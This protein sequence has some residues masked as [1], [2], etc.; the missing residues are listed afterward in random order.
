MSVPVKIK[1]RQS[2]KFPIFGALL[3]LTI[4]VAV[5]AIIVQDTAMLR[6]AQALFG[7]VPTS[8]RIGAAEVSPRQEWTLQAS[9][10][11]ANGRAWLWGFL[12]LPVTPE[13]DPYPDGVFYRF[14]FDGMCEG[15][16]VVLME[17]AEAQAA[18]IEELFELPLIEVQAAGFLLGRFGQWN[19]L[20]PSV[21]HGQR[22]FM[23]IPALRVSL[24]FYGDNLSPCVPA[25]VFSEAAEQLPAQDPLGVSAQH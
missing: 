1:V 20:R 19:V 3:I 24:G 14:D 6:K 2:P 5:P 8:I 9:R 11:R 12:P 22:K 16:D 10:A 25:D 18:P 4:L 17:M 21:E 7:R 23:M 13:E 15:E